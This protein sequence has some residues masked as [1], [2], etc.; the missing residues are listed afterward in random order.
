MSRKLIY[1]LV[2]GLAL[3]VSGLATNTAHALLFNWSFTSAAP[4]DDPGGIISG[5][6]DGLNEG[7]NDGMGLTIVVLSTP[8]GSA[9]TGEL[10]EGGWNFISVEGGS[11]GFTVTGGQ[12]TLAS[13]RYGRTN[14]DNLFF[15]TDPQMGTAVP[16]L[17]AGL[18]GPPSWGNNDDPT[19]FT[20]VIVQVPT[21]DVPEPATLALF[22]VGLAGLGFLRRRRVS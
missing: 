19:V 22:G 18:S 11:I 10:T 8:I 1:A 16:Q 17:V 3:S 12:I 21:T 15:G 4:F 7:S 9:P 6:I 14:G 13:V 2:A 20:P 5:T